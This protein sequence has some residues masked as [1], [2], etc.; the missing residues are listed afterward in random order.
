MADKAFREGDTKILRY[1]V[2]N[3][4]EEAPPQSATFTYLNA[5]TGEEVI[6]E[7][8]AGV[9]PADATITF[10][11]TNAN[12]GTSDP[13]FFWGVFVVTF[14]DGE[15]ATLIVHVQIKERKGKEAS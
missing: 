5:E 6:A 9:D 4:T 8:A 13:G 15:T 14:S 7:T 1:K 10:T 12:G 2:M 3:G 11:L